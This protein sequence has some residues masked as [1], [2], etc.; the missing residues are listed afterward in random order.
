MDDA[1]T[2][3]VLINNIQEKF[4]FEVVTIHDCFAVHANYADILCRL[5]KES[6][7][8]IYT[9]ENCI[10]KFHLYV[11]STIQAVY[12]IIEPKEKN[13]KNENITAFGLNKNG[14]VINKKGDMLLIPE[15]L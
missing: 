5:V 10:E 4:G 7:I 15:N 13:E 2:I 14:F 1:S 8:L 9:D 12:D 6:F 11:I 3:I